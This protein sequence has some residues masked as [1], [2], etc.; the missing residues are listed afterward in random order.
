MTTVH[1]GF[2]PRAWVEAAVRD[3]LAAT[4]GR[5]ASEIAADADLER[6]LGL[7]SMA[8]IQVNIA[9]EERLGV[10]VEAGESPELAVRTVDDLVAFVIE[11]AAPRG[12]RS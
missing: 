6:D 5:N 11:R 9:I 3:A 8:M 4:L 7:D 12:G 10:A 2:A 1:A